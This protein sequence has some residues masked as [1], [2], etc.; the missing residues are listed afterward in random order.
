MHFRWAVNCLFSRFFKNSFSWRAAIDA[1]QSLNVVDVNQLHLWLPWLSLSCPE[2][3][4][5][6]VSAFCSQYT[7]VVNIVM[8]PVVSGAWTLPED[9]LPVWTSRRCMGYWLFWEYFF[10]VHQR[11]CLPSPFGLLLA[12]YLTHGFQDWS[13]WSMADPPSWCR[14]TAF[15]TYNFD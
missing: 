4:F 8:Q 3:P 11:C 2:S 9:H 14:M 7:L 1:T 15:V 12:P 10:G 6:F 5:T 13:R